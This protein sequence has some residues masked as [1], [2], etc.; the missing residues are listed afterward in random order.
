MLSPKT[1]A[2]VDYKPPTD[3]GTNL[4]FQFWFWGDSTRAVYL[5]GGFNQLGMFWGWQT[6]LWE[7]QWALTYNVGSGLYELVLPKA[8]FP[9]S[10]AVRNTNSPS[11]IPTGT[12]QRS[13]VV[14]TIP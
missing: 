3:D 14:S 11:G 8:S 7:A 4:T 2:P 1:T 12:R 10:Q 13:V 6:F 9:E 5:N